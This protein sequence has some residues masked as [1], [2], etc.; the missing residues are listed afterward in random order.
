VSHPA[1]VAAYK[2]L[3]NGWPARDVLNEWLAVGA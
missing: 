1:T 3:S 2:L